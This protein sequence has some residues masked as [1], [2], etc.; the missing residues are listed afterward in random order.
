[1]KQKKLFAERIYTHTGTSQ[2]AGL[3]EGLK[4]LHIGCGKTKLPGAV[5]VDLLRLP[6]V[7]VV[8]NL[9]VR[10]WP[11][12]D[13][14]FDVVVAQAVLEHLD[15][16]VGTMEEVW[17]IS[18]NGASVVINVPYF[19]HPDAFGDLTHKHFFTSQSMDHFIAHTKTSDLYEY[20]KALFERRGFWYGW[21]GPGKNTFTRVIKRW[22]HKHPHLY[23]TYFSLLAPTKIVVWELGVKK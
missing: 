21:P 23:D 17:R 11:F 20:T 10:P 22:M 14:I 15:D 5:G 19:R 16:I 6:G 9:D 2:D 3:F 8:H 12:P 4:V 18:K 1:M 7:D 13:N